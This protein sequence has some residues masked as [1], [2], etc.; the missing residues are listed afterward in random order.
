[1]HPMLHDDTES[2]VGATLAI[3]LG[4]PGS[5]GRVHMLGIGGVGMAGLALL[6]KSKQWMVTGCDAYPG[7]LLPWLQ[8][9]G[10]PT[11]IGHDPMHLSERPAFIVR[12]PAV[13]WSEPELVD[14]R[15]RGIPVIDRGR[16]LPELLKS[17]N[18][19]AVAGTHGKT[20]TSSMIAWML[21]VGGQ[22]VSYCIGG[23]CPGL[24]AVARVDPVGW[25]V[26]EA[27]ESDGTL[28]YYHPDIAVITSIDLDHVDYF[29]NQRQLVEV[30]E[31]FVGH[32]RFCITPY[33]FG[34][35]LADVD[36]TT[37]GFEP[38]ATVQA[39]QPE[40]TAA[41]STFELVISGEQHGS[42]H[43]SVPGRHNILNALAAIA[44][45]NRAGWPVPR[46]VSALSTFTLPRRRYEQVAI[47][48][49]I[50]VISDYAH[51]P[52]EIAALI[53]QARL[54]SPKRIV[55]VFQPHRYSR[56]KAF[57]KEF[58]DVLQVLG[59]VILAPVYSASEAYIAGGTS[60]ELLTE[61]IRRGCGQF[62]LAD[63]VEDA[64]ARLQGTWC[65][66]DLV[67]VIGAGDVDQIGGWAASELAE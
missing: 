21:A 9:Q 41:G 17:R 48:R 54:A 53:E 59:R 40:L 12:S 50:R 29:Q 22:P 58:V 25:M 55:A 42:V 52:V 63:S 61:S 60:E 13:A 46:M 67:L 11:T 1:M 16:L 18:T 27:D 20:T 45:G 14:A 36:C 64:W 66:G 56:T 43:L 35:S 10:I 15:E 62:E 7:N 2:E 3:A 19:I 26:V 31:T 37:F 8:L 24:G 28:R 49:G 23:V 33:G 51:H 65:E 44:A 57:Q 32:S 34:L 39:R 38:E 6:L 47:G 4:P 5:N 30:F